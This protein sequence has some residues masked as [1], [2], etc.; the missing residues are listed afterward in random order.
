MSLDSALSV[1]SASLANIGLGYTLIS[2]NVANAN[3]PQYA[4]ETA[5]QYTLDA[6][7]VGYGA[8]SAPAGIVTNAALQFQLYG[9]N[10]AAAAAQTTAAALAN[11]QS[12]QGSVGGNTDLGSTLTALQNAFTALQADPANQTQQQA[13]VTAAATLAG[14]INTLAASYSQSAQAAQNALVTEVGQLNTALG[15]LGG[16]NNQIVNLQTQG[17]STADLQNQRNQV[18]N[19]I[20]GLTGAHFIEQGNGNILVFTSN[21]TQLPTDTPSPLSL[22]NATIGPSV[23]YPA[24][25]V[26]GITLDGAD[27]TSAFGSGGIGA[28]VTLRDTTLPSYGAALDGFSQGLA[29]RFAA[30][31]L[32]LFTDPNGNVPVQTGATA[33]SGFVGF[34]VDV[35]V[36]PAVV[37]NPALVVNGNL[38]IAGSPTGATA[39]TPNPD[40]Q[41]GFTGLIDRVLNFSFGADVQ[42]GV[43]Q[44]GIATT[45]L[46]ASGTLAANFQPGQTL[47]DYANGQTAANADDSNSASSAATETQATQ[48]SLAKALQGST[49][50]DIDSQ[51]ANLVQLQNAYAAN[52]KIIS[53]V[54]QL[55][56]ILLNEPGA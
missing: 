42:Q 19:T 27:I 41:A 4:T 25:G 50:V 2:Q 7:G 24:G 23:Y 33:Q 35:T 29:A 37:A 12:T 51:L 49:G 22:A 30:Q 14:Q 43:A 53:T 56:A 36:N 9:Q 45:G 10:A 52:A 16:L 39:F 34:S 54:Q 3:T 48:T 18:L 40:N 26:P 6:G 47:L 20:S 21:G 46:G 44:P 38:T 32:S 15:Q 55:Y 11:L 17:Q 13:V 28:N 1:A 8:A 5:A 31:G